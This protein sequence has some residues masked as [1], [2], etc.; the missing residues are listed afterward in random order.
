M[1]Q[2]HPSV[3]RVELDKY[4]PWDL[5]GYYFGHWFQTSTTPAQHSQWTLLFARITPPHSFLAHV[6]HNTILYCTRFLFA[7]RLLTPI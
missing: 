3:M 5:G 4:C 1:G 6:L 7:D 2:S